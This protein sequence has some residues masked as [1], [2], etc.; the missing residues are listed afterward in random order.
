M[1]GEGRNTSSRAAL[2]PANLC[3]TPSHSP[4]SR[5]FTVYSSSFSPIL[6]VAG[7]E[8]DWEDCKVGSIG[9]EE[10]AR[11]LLFLHSGKSSLE[12]NLPVCYC[13]L[14]HSQSRVIPLRVSFTVAAGP[15]LLLYTSERERERERVH[16]VRVL[17]EPF[18]FVSSFRFASKHTDFVCT[19]VA[20]LFSDLTYA[21]LL[22]RGSHRPR[23]ISRQL[24]SYSRISFP[25]IY[26][27]K[28]LSKKK[29]SKNSNF[30]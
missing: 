3:N 1:P 26:D 10:A 7:G 15:S 29:K 20:L 11:Q 23:I 4:S 24:T 5:F 13:K 8:R 9:L 22:A 28:P 30:F 16:I 21:C 19:R 18:L 27:N 2:C 25:L 17:R 12:S 6:R 14:P